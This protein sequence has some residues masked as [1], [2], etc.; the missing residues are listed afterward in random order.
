MKTIVYKLGLLLMILPFFS[1]GQNINERIIIG[2]QQAKQAIKNAL[3][4]KDYKPFY[5]TLVKD[6]ETAIAIAEA[7]LFKTY[8]KKNI[9]TQRPY[10]CYFIEAHWY[11]SGSLPKGWVGG[12][13]EIIISAK[14]GRVVKLIHGK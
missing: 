3:E 8:G 11:I 2:E 1:C 14:D 6:K 10:E 7:I 5:D 4:D 13:F 12:V 9:T